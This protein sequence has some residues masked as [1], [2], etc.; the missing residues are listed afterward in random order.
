MLLRPGTAEDAGFIERLSRQAFSVFDPDAGI[1]MLLL[2]RKDGVVTRVAARGGERLGFVMLE[3]ASGGAWVQAIAVDAK[4]RGQGVGGKLMA[5]AIRIARQA[6]APRLRLTTAQANVEALELFVKCGF[7][8][9]RRL[10]R[11][12]SGGQDACVLGRAL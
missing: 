10:P 3:F 12:Y 6:G 5:A 2:A 4:E 1:R 8:I 11:Y 7:A 9:E